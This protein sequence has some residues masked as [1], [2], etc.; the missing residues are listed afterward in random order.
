MINDAVL[1]K[2]LSVTRKAVSDNLL[3]DANSLAAGIEAAGW[4]RAVDG[5][6][7]YCPDEPSW[8]L[9]SSDHAPNLAFFLTDED[10][11]AV[12][13]TGQ[14]LARRLDQNEDLHQH[15]SGPDWP[16][17][18][19]DD[20][21]WTERTGLGPDWVMW[22]GGPARISLIV[23]PAHQPGR[24]RAPPHLHFQIERL[25][26]PSEGLLADPDRARHIATSGSAVAR[27]YLAGETDLPEDVIDVLHRD[28]DPA[29]VAAVVSGK[30]FWTM[31]AA[32]QEHTRWREGS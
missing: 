31:H 3:S 18:S 23:Q 27:W 20:P 19:L 29:V 15:E 22:E 8:S 26:T 5:G 7:W 1:G 10:A 11:A 32:A 9:L 21:R 24:H 25:D 16:T 14:E 6:H 13:T 30:K 17:W 2:V 4:V 12:F 28:P